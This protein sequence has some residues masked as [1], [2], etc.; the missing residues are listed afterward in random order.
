MPSTATELIAKFRT[1]YP[2]CTSANASTY[3]QDVLKELY[4]RLPIIRQTEVTINVT[5]GTREYDFDADATAIQ[6]IIYK[7]S[8]DETGWIVLDATNVDKLDAEDPYWRTDLTE[9]TPY[10]Y[11][12]RGAVSSDTAKNVIGF[13]EIPDTMTSDGYP[14]VACQISKYAALTTSETMPSN[15]LNDW[16]LTSGMRYYYAQDI[17]NIEQSEYWRVRYEQEIAKNQNHLMNLMGDDD[18]MII[19]SPVFSLTEA[20]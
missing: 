17:G 15:L 11:Y 14:I 2:D 6:E 7:P 8:S 16:V 1:R 12:I 5:D 13:I 3:L 4:G 20:V 18:P 19:L 10:K 9:G